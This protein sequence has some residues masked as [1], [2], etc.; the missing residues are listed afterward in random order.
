MDKILRCKSLIVETIIERL[1]NNLFTSSIPAITQLSHST[2][3]NGPT[4]FMLI[5]IEK[6][7]LPRGGGAK[8]WICQ[9]DAYGLADRQTAEIFCSATIYE[10]RFFLP[11]PNNPFSVS[12]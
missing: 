2:C 10:R 5:N 3:S 9:P 11:D 1:K 8:S 12:V 7:N 6:A 4:E